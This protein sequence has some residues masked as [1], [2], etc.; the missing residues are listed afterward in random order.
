MGHLNPC[1]LGAICA[2]MRVLFGRYP[3]HQL[4]HTVAIM[5]RTPHPL[6]H[7]SNRNAA[8]ASLFGVWE[9]LPSLA[10]ALNPHELGYTAAAWTATQRMELFDFA[11]APPPALFAEPIRGLQVREID[12]SDVFSHFFGSSAASH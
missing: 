8:R 3:E 2:F 10:P 9:E 7:P 6:S 5:N 11:D 1:C 12:G 4:S